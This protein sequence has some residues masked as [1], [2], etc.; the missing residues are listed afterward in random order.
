MDAKHNTLLMFI[1]LNTKLCLTRPAQY[2][3]SCYN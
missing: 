1:K 3:E 2:I